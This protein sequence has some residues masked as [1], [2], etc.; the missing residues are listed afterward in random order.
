MESKETRMCWLNKAVNKTRPLR[1][2]TIAMR[3]F[4]L[5]NSR[6]VWN[7]HFCVKEF[8]WDVDAYMALKA[9]G[10]PHIIHFSYAVEELYMTQNR[11]SPRIWGK[12]LKTDV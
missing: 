2:K 4:M 6:M 7:R 9:T 1:L 3:S 10:I 12:L 5:K 8:D 11:I